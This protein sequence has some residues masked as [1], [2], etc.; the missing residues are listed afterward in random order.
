MLQNN[1]KSYPVL[2]SLTPKAD[3]LGKSGPADFRKNL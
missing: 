1:Q 2:R 3:P